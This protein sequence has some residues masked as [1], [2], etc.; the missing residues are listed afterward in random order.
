MTEELLRIG[1]ISKRSGVSPELLRAWEHR[2]A[3]LK[4]AR[5]HGG[6][7]LYT[8]DDLERVRV[9]REH[10]ASGFAA[11]EAAALASRALPTGEL[12]ER[13]SSPMDLRASLA[14]AL[15]HLDEPRAQGVF[16]RALS[17]TTLDTLLGGIVLPYLR[18]LGE[19]WQ[20]GQISVAQEHFASALVRGRLLG[21]ARG[22]GLGVG[23]PAVLACLPGEQHDIGLIA[24]GLALRARGW[25]IVHLGTD[26]PV[27]VLEPI[28]QAVQAQ[29]VIVSAARVEPVAPVISDLEALARRHS[30]GLGG[31]GASAAEIN[32]TSELLWL[33]GD[34]ISE[35]E[36][37]GRPAQTAA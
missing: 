16:D 19:R 23:P 13:N 7:R 11:A 31:H 17:L 1:E 15:D 24:F 6:L 26:T 37:V 18:E 36:R 14:H 29:I 35:A 8:R 2:Y 25:R 22:W 30:V 28:A 10:L 34:V 27:D 33:T 12:G 21:L 4:P 3:L 32:E 9:M 5:S 20:R